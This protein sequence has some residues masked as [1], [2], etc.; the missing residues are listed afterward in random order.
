VVRAVRLPRSPTLAETFSSRANSVGFLRLVLATSVL[1]AHTWPLGL[2][3]G[4]FGAKE[5]GDQA[6]LGA[7]GVY[8]FFVLSGFLITASGLRFGLG[9]FAWHRFL[10]IFPG[11]WACLLVTALVVAPLVTLYQHGSLVG[12]WDEPK[13]PLTYLRAN[14]WTAQRTFGI[15]DVFSTTP[16]GKL[17][18]GVSV[19]N[20]S[21]W[22]LVYELCCYILVGTLAFT[23]VLRRAPRLVLVLL[24]TVYLALVGDFVQQARRG[25]FHAVTLEHPAFGPFPLI[26]ALG[27]KYMLPLMLMFL[28]GA[29]FQLYKDRVPMH[30]VLVAG[31]AVVAV[32]TAFLGGFLILGMPAYAYLLIAGACY[33]PKWLQGIGRKRDYSYGIYI[34]AFPM[35]QTIALLT[36]AR[37]GVLAYMGMSLAA[38]VVLAALSWHLVE[39]P[40]MR[41]KDWTPRVPARWR[42]QPTAEAPPPDAP[43]PEAPPEIEPEPARRGADRVG[44][45]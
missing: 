8:G 9:R 21:L 15:H 13:G 16:Y 38:T 34:Y 17:V 22:S 4:N 42:R 28:I 37:W 36:G 26:G 23:G 40:A 27:L 31:A 29:A 3:R 6:D 24:V 11:L 25:D 7:L 32:S 33:L 18:S 20:G 19:L 1:V 45:A 10:R 44:S 2:G 41:L 43:P 12:F 30:P 35:Q 14:W 5:T 39:H